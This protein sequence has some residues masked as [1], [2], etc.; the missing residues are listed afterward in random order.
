V[1]QQGKQIMASDVTVGVDAVRVAARDFSKMQFRMHPDLALRYDYRPKGGVE[2]RMF[3]RFAS[4]VNTASGTKIGVA[5]ERLQPYMPEAIVTISPA[6]AAPYLRRSELESLL[7]ML[8]APHFLKIEIAHDFHAGSVVTAPFA[9]KYLLVGKSVKKE[10]PAYPGTINYGSRRSPVF[11]RGYWKKP[12]ASY[13]IEIEL[14]PTWI[15]KHSIA[16]P[17]DFLR[18]PELVCGHHIAFYKIDPL[19]LT[20]ALTRI[21]APVAP[22]FRKVIARQHD[23]QEA[24]H[25]LRHDVGLENTLRVLTPLATNVRVMRAHKDWAH[26]W[27]NDRRGQHQVA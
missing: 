14:H 7:G 4:Y 18:L 22:T 19:K 21:G 1:A 23:L 24:L 20:A 16:T 17:G 27:Q 10:N 26:G 2:E 15:K 8:T 3:A 25:F 9:H 5:Y 12:I 11:A 6:D 13:R